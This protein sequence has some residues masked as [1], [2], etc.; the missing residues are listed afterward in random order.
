MQRL[1]EFDKIT[2]S[3]EEIDQNLDGSFPAS[4]PPSWNLGTDHGVSGT[5]TAQMP[6]LKQGTYLLSRPVNKTDH[7]QGVDTAPVTLLMY[8]AYECQYCVEGN[9]IVKQIQQEFGENLRFVFRH[10]PRF[11]VHPHA[12]AAA[13]VAEAAGEQGKF[14]AMHDKLFEN[15]YRLDGVHLVL[16]AKSVR[17]DMKR[18]HRAITQRVFAQ[19]VWEDLISGTESAVKGTPT[20]FINGI[21]H[22]ESGE[23]DVLLAAIQKAM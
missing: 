9:K 17:L 6:L 18:F 20:Y 1:N 21:K 15:Y 16:F 14:W 13:Q 11:N 5:K 12:A 8:G 23:L 19:K 2:I 10:F 7:I 3:E 22:T 4:D